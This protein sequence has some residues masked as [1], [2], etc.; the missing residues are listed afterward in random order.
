MRTLLVSLNA[1]HEHENPAP[2]YLKAAC[3]AA[4]IRS[5]SKE[6]P[7][8]T[9]VAKAIENDSFA[10]TSAM[11]ESL[12]AIA[13]ASDSCSA[14]D[15]EIYVLS[16]TI[17]EE[18]RR[19]FAA[20]VRQRPDVVGLSCYIWNRDMLLKLCRDLKA[21]FPNTYIVAGG[22]EVSYGDGGDEF[23]D[24]GVDCIIAGEGE[25][26]FP[27]LLSMLRDGRFPNKEKLAEFKTVMPALKAEH[28]FFLRSSEYLTQLKG[29]IAYVEASRGC[30]YRCSYCLSS[31]NSTMTLLPLDEVFLSIKALVS[32]GVRIIKFLDRT[33]NL[34]EK[35]TQT[36]WNFLQ[37]FAGT[38][39][40][41][42]FEISPDLLTEE[43][44]STLAACIPGLF[45][46]EAGI[47]SVHE[48][49]LLNIRRKM[50]VPKALQNLGEI[51]KQGNVHLHADLIVGLPGEGLGQIIESVDL[52][53]ETR[54]HHL[55][56]GFLKLLKGT[57]IWREKSSWGYI[58][59]EYAPYE[60]LASRTLSAQEVIRLKEVEETIERFYNSGRFLLTLQWL[61][62][63]YRSAYDLFER[64]TDFQHNMAILEHAVSSET[65][66]K[67]MLAFLGK[68]LDSDYTNAVFT[69]LKLD[70][71]C[72]HKNPFTPRWLDLINIEAI[73]E[74]NDAL[75]AYGIDVTKF[76]GGKSA[77]KNRF[78]AAY[79]DFSP[80]EFLGVYRLSDQKGNIIGRFKEGT[81]HKA[82]VLIDTLEINPVLGRPMV[83]LSGY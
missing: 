70:W 11:D 43:M 33:F 35:R 20:I 65:L 18:L 50:N 3:D 40:T 14:L 78:Y 27:E 77:P 63:R 37:Q 12:P 5:C 39:V 16:R 53:T 76:K 22:P 61:L 67:C 25:V 46:L 48:K 73:N 36:I 55:Q 15:S 49:T 60:I 68:M 29:K 38:G 9:D 81:D 52:L 72:A 17:N 10:D 59:R 23:I 28:M 24:A 75:E 51:S 41:F 66:F 30:P 19:I 56:L 26:R 47:Q 4:F 13:P 71:V 42:H 31:E 57:A 58:S 45:Q 82:R 6:K 74:T 54:P 80:G 34:D 44:L 79:I 83:R 8:L 69:L 62:V 32:A 21:C 1:R 2:W 7:G 64:L